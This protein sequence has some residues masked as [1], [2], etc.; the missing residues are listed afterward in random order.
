MVTAEEA[1]D[2]AYRLKLFSPFAYA[3]ARLPFSVKRR[4]QV[5]HVTPG[6]RVAPVRGDLD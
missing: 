2:L 3:N 5:A 1:D 4:N 6:G